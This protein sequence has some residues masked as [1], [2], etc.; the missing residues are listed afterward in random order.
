MKRI[1]VSQRVDVLEH[2]NERRDALDQRLA[3]F[4][5]AIN[6]VAVPVPNNKNVVAHILDIVS[7]D[8]VILSGGNTE[9]RY[10]GNAPERDE[11]DS[12]LI[13]YALNRGCPLI[14]IC[15]GMQSIITYFGGTLCKVNGH[16]ASK[17][18]LVGSV[19]RN[20]NSYHEWACTT[21]PSCL[22]VIG[23]AE[24]GVIEAIVHD[25]LPIY[26]IMWHPERNYPFFQDDIKMFDQFIN[27][28]FMK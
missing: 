2:H 5:L 3:E 27:G 12:L 14:G 7:P 21:L 22:Q 15:R 16:V 8:V 11:V 13:S 23:R 18:M 19:N 25:K 1:I 17:H 4:I 10:G 9:V 26:G 6:S 28:G 20:V 24:D